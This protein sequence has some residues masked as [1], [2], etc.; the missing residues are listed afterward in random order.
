MVNYKV[1]YCEWIDAVAEAGWSK[2]NEIDEVHLCKT[3][4]YLVRETKLSIT[5]ATTISGKEV[6]AIQTIP[7]AWI[8]K[9]KNIRL[10]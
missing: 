5:V 6:N 3:L 4:G 8:K 10:K 1:I 7:K 9:R 2:V